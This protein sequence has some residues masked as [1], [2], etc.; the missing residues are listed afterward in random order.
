MLT[1]FNDKRDREPRTAVPHVVAVIACTIMTVNETS[2]MGG[3]DVLG[4]E[5]NYDRVIIEVSLH[6]H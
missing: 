3:N 1:F 4:L 2:G 6:Y 5:L